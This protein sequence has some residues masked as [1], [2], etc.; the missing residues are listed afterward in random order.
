M[1]TKEI[2][3]VCHAPR[4]AHCFG[5]LKVG[6]AFVRGGTVTSDEKLD[7]A[8]IDQPYLHTKKDGSLSIRLPS[9]NN[10]PS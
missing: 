7:E 8:L 3:V 4:D 9:L 2:R 10:I 6:A 1:N 5:L